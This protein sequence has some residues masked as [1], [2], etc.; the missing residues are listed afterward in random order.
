MQPNI[1][2][3]LKHIYDENQL[4]VDQQTGEVSFQ[5]VPGKLGTF[6]RNSLETA[7]RIKQKLG[8]SVITLTVGPQEAERSIREGLAMGADKA[9]LVKVPNLLEL[10]ANAVANMMVDQLKEMQPWHILITS[11]GGADTYTS[12]LPS[13]IAQKLNLPLLGFLRSIEV[14]EDGTVKGERSTEKGIIAISAK[15]PVV[16][17]V[18][19]EINEPRIPTL[20]QI[21]ASTKKEIRTVA[22]SFEAQADRY[23]KTL[24]LSAK[25]KERKRIIFDGT[26]QEIVSKLIDFLVGEGVLS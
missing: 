8:G 5:G 2:V 23:F 24:S 10:S 7:L 16:V 22:P 6:D 21:M 11:E 13:I 14:L 1:V 18:V 20:L 12:V 9:V 19:S 15:L 25:S 3:L 26:V 17:S 4:K